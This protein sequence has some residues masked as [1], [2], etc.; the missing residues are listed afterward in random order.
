MSD[1]QRL[2]GDRVHV[3]VG[4]D[5]CVLGLR[6]QLRDAS[7]AARL[8]GR[9]QL[10]DGTGLSVEPGPVLQHA[11]DGLCARVHGDIV[12]RDPALQ[13]RRPLR[14]VS[15]R[16]WVHVPG[17]HGLFVERDGRRRERVRTAALHRRVRMRGRFSLRC[18]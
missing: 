13:R 17:G 5:Q 3:H 2:P 7:A 4:S 10:P 18:R 9:H 11:L 1:E 12:R 14:G 16:G 6:Y 15:V 8:H